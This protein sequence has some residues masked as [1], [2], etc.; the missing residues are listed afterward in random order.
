MRKPMKTRTE[1]RFAEHAKHVK[2]ISDGNHSGI[3][4]EYLLCLLR[5]RCH[6]MGT[7]LPVEDRN[8]I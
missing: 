2:M 3:P 6:A 8:T 7:S 4:N 1:N 5:E